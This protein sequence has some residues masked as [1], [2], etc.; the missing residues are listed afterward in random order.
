[1]SWVFKSG[2]PCKPLMHYEMAR[3]EGVIIERPQLLPSCVTNW[4]AQT[5]I[6]AIFRAF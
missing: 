3:A 6:F 2:A 1:M 5:V 4:R